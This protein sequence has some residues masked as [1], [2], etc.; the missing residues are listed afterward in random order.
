MLLRFLFISKRKMSVQINKQLTFSKVATTKHTRH[1][2]NYHNYL[3]TRKM[4]SFIQSSRV[5]V[6]KNLSLPLQITR[7]CSYEPCVGFHTIQCVKN[8]IKA[9]RHAVQ[10]KSL[11]Q[12]PHARSTNLVLSLLEMRF[13]GSPLT[14]L[15]L[16]LNV[17]E[18]L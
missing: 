5:D 17:I 13:R 1:R 12:I 11:F 10:Y 4:H 18:T 8:L 6:I 3:H 7:I 9:A 14:M 16:Y 15:L 2:L